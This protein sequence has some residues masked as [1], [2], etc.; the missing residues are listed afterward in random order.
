VLAAVGYRVLKAVVGPLVWLLTRP[1]V[2]GAGHV[3]AR[4]P[5][6]L[7]ANHLSVVD[8]FVLCLVVRRPITFVAK[9]EYFTGGGARG[10]L[11]RRFFRTAGQVPVDRSGAGA[12]DAAL[13][14]ARALLDRGGVWGIHPE[15]SRSPDGRLHRGRT[16]VMRV[17]LDRD[18]PVVP[19]VLRGTE[20]VH[21]RGAR[22][23]RPARVRVTFLPPMDLSTW[24]AMPDRRTAARRATDALMRRLASA[25]GQEYVDTYAA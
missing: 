11:L 24:R 15:G 20:R 25:S 21:R 9:S 19:V 5:V 2:T 4:G 13:D 7:A 14:A 3:P 1:R 8:S 18:V 12:G 17:A 10:A 23:W 6:V 22:W 16:G